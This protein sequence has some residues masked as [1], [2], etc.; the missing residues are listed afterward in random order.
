MGGGDEELEDVSGASSATGSAVAGDLGAPASPGQP[1]RIVREILGEEEA[2]VYLPG[3]RARMTFRYV[4]G[5][6]PEAYQQML[7]RGWRR[8]GRM[9]FRPACAACH[10]CRSLRVDVAAFQ[11]SRSMRRNLQ[12]NRDLE[13]QVGPPSLSV[14]HLGLYRRYHRDMAQRRGWPD[15]DIDPLD[16]YRTFVEGFE[17]FG[18]E[19]TIADR[20]RLVGVALFDLLPAGLSAVYCYYEPDLRPRG[21]GVFAV[22]RQIQ[23]A[24]HRGLSWVYLG[25]RVAGNASMRYKSRYRPHQLL[26]DRPGLVEDPVWRAG[27]GS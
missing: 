22:L 5:C 17:G 15:R 11:P 7:E 18:H 10:E 24:R 6:P 26:D 4:E 3:Q 21:L 16:Y 27:E 23:L 13:V 20:G 14:A 1:L 9:F 8:F 19:L 12:S 25:F 2:C